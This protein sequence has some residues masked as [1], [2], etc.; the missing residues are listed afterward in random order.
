MVF[1]RRI[2]TMM[3]DYNISM[4]KAIEWDMDGE[5]DLDRYDTHKM[6]H[7]YVELNN[8]SEETGDFIVGI[9]LGLIN[10]RMLT[11]IV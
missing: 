3:K 1:E 6:I 7:R 8:L 5:W 11:A 9:Y 10:D 4:S 2:L